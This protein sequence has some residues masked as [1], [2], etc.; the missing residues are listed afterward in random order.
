M[1]TTLKDKSNK[2]YPLII[3]NKF[4][5]LF[6]LSSICC[7]SQSNNFYVEKNTLTWKTD[8][9]YTFEAYRKIVEN[10]LKLEVTKSSDNQ[11]KG[12]AKNLK[13]TCS[14]ASSFMKEEFDA[15]FIINFI[16]NKLSIIVFN[17]RFKS[18]DHYV[19]E[20]VRAKVEV[21]PIENQV[22]KKMELY[23]IIVRQRKIL[24]V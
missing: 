9:D 10:N 8:L 4:L 3:M 22:L 19:F 15:D 18:Y 7:F 21:F 2:K 5:L 1:V 13:Y 11:I 14:G 23:E 16:D 24:N 17:L 6:L 20:T 12:V